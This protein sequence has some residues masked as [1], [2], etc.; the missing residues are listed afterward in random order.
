[1]ANPCER[2][3]T[4]P[5]KAGWRLADEF[6]TAEWLKVEALKALDVP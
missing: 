5:E 4:W 3:G 2:P 1:M 6:R